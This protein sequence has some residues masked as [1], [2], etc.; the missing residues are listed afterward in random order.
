MPLP[1]SQRLQA[2]LSHLAHTIQQCTAGQQGIK[3]ATEKQDDIA[4]V[5][6]ATQPVAAGQLQ[7]LS[8]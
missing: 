3:A 4:A 6:R 5:A 8:L 7:P 2:G 1:L